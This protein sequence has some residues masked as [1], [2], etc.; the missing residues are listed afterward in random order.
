MLRAGIILQTIW[1]ATCALPFATA[2]AEDRPKI[3]FEKTVLDVPKLM[4]GGAYE[5]KFW[6]TNTGQAVLEVK[7]PET[8]CG[9]T[10]ASVKP[11]KL[12]PGQ[13]GEISFALDLTNVRGKADKGIT[14]PSNDPDSPMTHL[15]IKTDVTPLFE[16]SPEILFFGLVQ[17]GRPAKG[18]IDLKRLDGKKLKIT[19]TQ[20][21]DPSTIKIEPDEKSRGQAARLVVETKPEGKPGAFSDILL[22]FVD[23]S[24]KPNLL[25]PLAGQLLGGIKAEPQELVW[26]LPP[27]ER[28]PGP[29]PDATTIR[30]LIVSCVQQGHTLEL[31]EFASDLEDLLVKI[32]PVEDGKKYEVLLKLEQAHKESKE[33]LLTFETSLPTQPKLEVPIKINVAKP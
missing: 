3:Q 6:F 5:G 29:D 20:T 27:P 26:E 15:I 11:E 8:S 33:G 12:Q 14:V 2:N 13:A 31:G 21:R 17:A 4:E 28:W 1:V 10:V 30:K 7:Q 23:D 32:T 25:I 24:P 9:C 18:T 22:I 16:Y 19:K